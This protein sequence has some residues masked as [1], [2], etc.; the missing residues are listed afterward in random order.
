MKKLLS[1]STAVCVLCGSVYAGDKFPIALTGLTNKVSCT[2]T[3][4][5]QKGFIEQIYIN[6][7]AYPSYTGTVTIT[8]DAGETLLSSVA[9]TADGMYTVR[10]PVCGN[11]GV[12]VTGVTATNSMTR[13]FLVSDKVIAAISVATTNNP[14]TTHTVPI[15]IWLDN[16]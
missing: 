3:S 7:P 11:N 14:T 12:T 6:I 2:V 10:K 13:Y 16:K 8:T 15:T 9:V 4:D 1:I 5:I